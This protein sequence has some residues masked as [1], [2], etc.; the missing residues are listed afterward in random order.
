[1]TEL[2]KPADGGP[3]FPHLGLYQGADG[4]LHPTPTQ[5][6]GMSKRE[7]YAALALSGMLANHER[8]GSPSDFVMDAFDFADAMLAERDKSN[9]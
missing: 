1:M 3:A 9:E 4:N 5:H 8:D 7:L 2:T 6:G